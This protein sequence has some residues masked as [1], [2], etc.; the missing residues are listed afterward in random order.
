[1]LNG[2]DLTKQSHIS[3]AIRD[4]G[5]V[6]LKANEICINKA[7]AFVPVVYNSTNKQYDPVQRDG[8]TVIA[9]MPKSAYLS[10]S[11]YTSV[12]AAKKL[13]TTFFV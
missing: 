9:S 6:P 7:D 10:V 13:T 11:A 3:N 12:E 8:G 1:L 4:R 2:V 5:I